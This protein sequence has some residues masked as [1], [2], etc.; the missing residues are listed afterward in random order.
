MGMDGRHAAAALLPGKTQYTC[1]GR[2][3]NPTDGLDGRGKSR[4]PTGS[5]PRSFKS[6]AS[7][8]TD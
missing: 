3:V 7:L 8:Y 4:P 5:E 1:I 6:V 2:W